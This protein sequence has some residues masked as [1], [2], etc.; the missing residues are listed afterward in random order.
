M[1]NYWK[2]GGTLDLGTYPRSQELQFSLTDTDNEKRF[3][4]NPPAGWSA[5][6]FTYKYNSYGFRSR[7]FDLTETKPRILSL[8]CS[9]TAGVGVP[10]HDSWSEQL[11]RTYFPDHVVWNAGLGGASA[12]TVAR[13]AVNMIP[14]LKPDMVVILWPSVNRF[15]TYH[16]GMTK[17][18]TQFIGPW[19]KD[20]GIYAHDN[21]AYNNQTKNKLI[22]ELLQKMYGFT[23][24]AIDAD[25]VMQKLY[26]SIKWPVARDGEHYGIEWHWQVAYDFNLQ[27]S[28]PEDFKLKYTDINAYWEKYKDREV[29]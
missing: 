24:L 9:H 10:Q 25:D 27:Y 8:G 13:L 7:E 1:M 16:N 2:L 29:K 14:I 21:T 28:N 17:T 22:L 20:L 19:E 12:D 18:D 6:S 5:D 11:G 26:Y 3:Y 4:K 23:L 15:E